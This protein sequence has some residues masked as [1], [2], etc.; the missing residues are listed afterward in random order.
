MVASACLTLALMHLLVW[1][2][3]PRQWAHLSFSVVAV[4]VAVITVMELMGMRAVTAEQMGTLMRW[5]HVPVLILFV[6]VVWFV[7]SYF[8][9]GR[10]WLGWTVIGARALVT[11]V[12]LHHGPER[13]LPRNHRIEARVA[14][15]RRGNRTC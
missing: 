14:S 2:K 13:V 8:D 11:L 10:P 6:A 3:Q 5:V 1:F 9:A 7:R 4:A 12:E 15:R